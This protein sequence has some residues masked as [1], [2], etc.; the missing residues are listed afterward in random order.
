MK[1]KTK[2]GLT[3][4]LLSLLA[5]GGL[6]QSKYVRN[7]TIEMDVTSETD[8][9]V[10][11]V[12]N[13]ATGN[14][15]T[16][17]ATYTIPKTGYYALQLRGGDGGTNVN[18]IGGKG[19]IVEAVYYFVK[20]QQIRYTLGGP[21]GHYESG[22]KNETPGGSNHAA[23]GRGGYGYGIFVVDDSRDGSGG[24]GSSAVEL[25]TNGATLLVAGGGGGGAA[26][27]AGN[28][29]GGVGASNVDGAYGTS[30]YPITAGK[31]SAFNLSARR[32]DDPDDKNGRDGSV[33]NGWGGGGSGGGFQASWAGGRQG[34]SSS[35]AGAGAGGH[36]YVA[37]T[38]N[39]VGFTALTNAL[40][41][42]YTAKLPTSGPNKGDFIPY[43][44][45][46]N[47][48]GGATK[49]GQFRIAY[50]WSDT[51]ADHTAIDNIYK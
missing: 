27:G 43:N 18:G 45:G 44:N 32:T 38:V 25:L 35:P 49:A 24:G 6:T 34:T 33:I 11:M 36:S 12:N 31:L 46:A 47:T 50:L 1:T 39:G 17:W 2:I 22:S 15:A 10:F 48:A 21:G 19:G 51:T 26:N 37:P 3:L 7:A 8:P 4:G 5:L 20:D 16:P 9:G 42:T 28:F 14:S 40:K 23:G 41:T 13:T 29:L 30:N